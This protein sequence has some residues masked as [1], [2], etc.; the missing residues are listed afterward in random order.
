MRRARCVAAV[1]AVVTAVALAGALAGCD[2]EPLEL[3][4]LVFEPSGDPE[5]PAV[6][7]RAAQLSESHLTL[8]VVGSGLSDVY[9]V[10]FRLEHEPGAL[11]VTSL[12]A[13]PLWPGDALSAVAQPDP[14]VVVAGLS[15][16][17]AATGFA[18]QDDVLAVLELELS[19]FSTIEFVDGHN[20]VAGADGTEAS[21]VNWLGGRVGWR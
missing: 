9:G 15:A 10:A 1:Q 18:A 7:L 4:T 8:E 17:G 2:T 11:R 19:A 6:Y 13:G 5:P 21:D 16:R 14:S 3:P 12:S 20:A